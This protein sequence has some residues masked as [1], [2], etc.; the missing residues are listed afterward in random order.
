MMHTV[1]CKLRSEII[2][3]GLERDKLAMEVNFARDRLDNFMKEFDHQVISDLCC[4]CVRLCV[5]VLM[6]CLNMPER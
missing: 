5:C 4:V 2:S 3:I 1:F 6:L